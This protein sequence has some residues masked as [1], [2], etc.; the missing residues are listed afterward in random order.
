MVIAAGSARFMRAFSKFGLV[1][2]CG[3]TWFL[4]RILGS[5]RAMGL[6]GDQLSA[7]QAPEWR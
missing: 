6:T 1:P 4:P 5:A 2:D 7:E 3:G